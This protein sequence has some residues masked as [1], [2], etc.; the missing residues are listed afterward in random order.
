MIT[1]TASTLTLGEA[2]TR[3]RRPALI[4]TR[5][6]FASRPQ[7]WCWGRVQDLLPYWPEWLFILLLETLWLC[8]TFLLPVP[9][10]PA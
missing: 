10:C 4:V 9:G 6:L 2:E 7:G 5:T 3:R 8:L 1:L